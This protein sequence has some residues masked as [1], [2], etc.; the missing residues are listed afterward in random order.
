L[1]RE[2]E[3]LQRH[4]GRLEEETRYGTDQLALIALLVSIGLIGITGGA[5]L[6]FAIGLGWYLF[7]YNKKHKEK[8]RTLQ[9]VYEEIRLINKEIEELQG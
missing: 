7:D 2:V 8:K 5:S 3:D 4:A 9:H 6:I 1:H